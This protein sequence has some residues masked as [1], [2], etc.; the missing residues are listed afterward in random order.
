METIKLDPPLKLELPEECHYSHLE[1]AIDRYRKAMIECAAQEYGISV[2]DMTKI[3]DEISR[4]ACEGLP[5]NFFELVR[6][7]QEANG[8]Q[9]LPI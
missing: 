7:V 8:I 1:E 9:T 6:Q 5:D 2:E 3:A 4:R